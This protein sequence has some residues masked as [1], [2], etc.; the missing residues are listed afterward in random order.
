MLSAETASAEIL[1]IRFQSVRDTTLSLI[2]DLQ[3]EDTVVQT[4]PDVSPTKWH[5]AHV[6]WFFERFVLEPYLEN[7]SRF[8]DQYHYLFNSYYNSVGDMHARPKRGLLSRPALADVLE[9]RASV[10]AAMHALLIAHGDNDE[11][12]ELTTLASTTNN[13]TRNCC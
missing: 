10:D 4:M 3:A 7:Y 13:N 5:L 11:I 9:Y 6:T 1:S 8:D 2:A 12:V